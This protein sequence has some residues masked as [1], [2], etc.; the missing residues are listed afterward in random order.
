[1]KLAAVKVLVADRVLARAVWRNQSQE[2]NRDGRG[3]GEARSCSTYR[4]RVAAQVAGDR[5]GGG[6]SNER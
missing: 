2:G 3:F 5:G 4:R 1:M 6:V